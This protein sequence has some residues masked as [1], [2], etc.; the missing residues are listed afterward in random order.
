MRV[1]SLGGGMGK[2]RLAWED[3]KPPLMLGEGLGWFQNMSTYP[4]LREEGR[5]RR[6]GQGKALTC[7]L[8]WPHCLPADAE[9]L[10]EPL[11]SL[12]S[13]L[14]VLDRLGLHR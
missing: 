14:S 1:I 3:L 12:P 9:T 4:L 7:G 5:G 6:E 8:L 13:E 11:L 2:G 10:E